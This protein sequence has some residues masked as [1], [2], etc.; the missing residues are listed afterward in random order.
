[1]SN[2]AILINLIVLDVIVALSLIG[3]GRGR[4]F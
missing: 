3:F 4:W 2:T 1:M